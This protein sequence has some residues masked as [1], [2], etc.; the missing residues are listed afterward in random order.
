MHGSPP[1]PNP[2]QP[3]SSSE[4][5][6]ATE[7]EAQVL[8]GGHVD[9]IVRR[10]C[11]AVDKHEEQAWELVEAIRRENDLSQEL[12]AATTRSAQEASQQVL[13]ERDRGRR[14]RTDPRR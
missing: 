4:V 9:E 6:Q 14:S 7:E 5:R 10:V 8:R 12:T 1:P 3:G 2:Y 13:D 11:E